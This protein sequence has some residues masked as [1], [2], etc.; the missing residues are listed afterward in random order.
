MSQFDKDDVES[1]PLKLDALGIRM[2]SSMAYA[3]AEIDRNTGERVDLDDRPGAARRTSRPFAMIRTTHTLGCFQ[4]SP[5]S[6][7]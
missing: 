6:G 1:R 5:G 3:A 2:Q 4:Q 7:S